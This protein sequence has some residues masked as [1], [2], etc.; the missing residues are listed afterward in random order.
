MRIYFCL[1]DMDEISYKKVLRVCL[2]KRCKSLTWF[3]EKSKRKTI[4]KIR[5]RG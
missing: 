3:P 1:R 4:K 2:V 5:M